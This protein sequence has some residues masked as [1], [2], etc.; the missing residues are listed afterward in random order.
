VEAL[1]MV[2]FLKTALRN[3]TRLQPLQASVITQVESSIEMQLG[4]PELIYA[5]LTTPP[6]PVP[7]PAPVIKV[8]EDRTAMYIIMLTGILFGAYLEKYFLDCYLRRK[9]F[10]AEKRLWR[11]THPG[12]PFPRRVATGCICCRKYHLEQQDLSNE[13]DVYAIAD[14]KARQEME[15]ISAFA[16]GRKER[17]SNKGKGK[18]S[19]YAIGGGKR[20]SMAAAAAL[21][22]NVEGAK[23]KGD[24]KTSQTS[25][26]AHSE[27][28]E[29]G[30]EEQSKEGTDKS[31]D[32]ESKSTES[33]GSKPSS[34]GASAGKKGK[35]KA[36]AKQKGPSKG[37]R[38]SQGAEPSAEAVAAA[39]AIGDKS[40][41]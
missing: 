14:L 38:G 33:D 34:A 18:G 3:Q 10:R 7:T 4:Q 36:S 11:I 13:Y 22:L 30:E 29:E 31:E 39:E 40:N 17:Q 26:S 1:F 41:S 28:E 35:N 15:Q 2:E 9:A 24:K 21:G 19:G 25:G 32:D 20:V 23:K 12:E 37:K 16:Q 6:P 27:Y 8:K 5:T